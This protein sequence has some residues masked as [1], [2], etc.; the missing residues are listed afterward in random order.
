MN[1]T[2]DKGKFG[3]WKSNKHRCETIFIWCK[4]L[5]WH[6]KI[7]LTS[8]AMWTYEVEAVPVAASGLV[9][10]PHSFAPFD[11]VSHSTTIFPISWAFYYTIAYHVVT[12]AEPRET[13]R[14][15]CALIISGIPWRILRL[16]LILDSIKCDVF[17]R[18]H[19]T[20]LDLIFF[21]LAQ[22]TPFRIV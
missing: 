4:H 11:L 14:L 20:L 15:K 5:H 17:P 19:N 1:I 16:A 22:Y 12:V 21:C 2:N 13:W 9:W 18:N 7:I 10:P 3:A 6:E 8:L